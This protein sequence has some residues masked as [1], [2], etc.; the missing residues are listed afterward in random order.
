MQA[1][2]AFSALFSAVGI[3][4]A[5]DD[6][7]TRD[8]Y[9][10]RLNAQLARLLDAEYGI[11]AL[12]PDGNPLGKPEALAMAKRYRDTLGKGASKSRRVRRALGAALDALALGLELGAP[13]ADD[14][15]AACEVYAAKLAGLVIAGGYL[16]DADA[17]QK[18]I[19]DPVRATKKAESADDA[20]DADDAQ[21]AQGKAEK[22]A[23]DAGTSTDAAGFAAALVTVLAGLNAG[24]YGDGDK[25]ALR[26]ALGVG[27]P[28]AAPVAPAPVAAPMAD[29][30]AL[31]SAL[32]SAPVEAVAD[33]TA[34]PV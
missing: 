9:N 3:A 25:A 33:A 26:A 21:Q 23:Q 34:A 2:F 11:P 8:A 32:L 1:P 24:A 19:P 22:P 4:A 13:P 5:F 10:G 31:L 27:I 12:R 28:D 30:G 6:A 16:G 14:D 15:R 7:V 18:A 17:W 29:A 20:D